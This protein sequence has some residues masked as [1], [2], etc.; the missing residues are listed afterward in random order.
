M[1]FDKAY[2]LRRAV[3]FFVFLSTVIVYPAL[4]PLFHDPA[5]YYITYVRDARDIFYSLILYPSAFFFSGMFCTKLR[6]T[7]LIR[8]L[9]IGMIPDFLVFLPKIIK[10]SHGASVFDLCF[11][12]MNCILLLFIWMLGAL[13]L[14]GIQCLIALVRADW[15]SYQR[16]RKDKKHFR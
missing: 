8:S 10:V 2:L 6:N 7:S 9:P 16:K 3:I 15:I 13:T 12:L 5:V 14:L 4:D 11:L 1:K